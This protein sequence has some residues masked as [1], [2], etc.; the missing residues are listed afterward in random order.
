MKSL[1]IVAALCAVASADP[2]KPIY[3]RGGARNVNLRDARLHRRPRAGELTDA[4]TSI[5]R[6]P[7]AAYAARQDRATPSSV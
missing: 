6:M 3:I 5:A 4:G 1:A 2:K 7:H